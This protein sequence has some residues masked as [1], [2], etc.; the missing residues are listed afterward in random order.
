MIKQLLTATGIITSMLLSAQKNFWASVQNKTSLA[1]ASMMERTTSPKDFKLYSL[2]LQGIKAELAKAP[3]RESSDENF[4]LK[5]PTASGQLV[6]Y[7]VKE[8]PV[9]AK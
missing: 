3:L 9:M 2:D 8:A 1:T 5:F 7:V 4:V 6:D